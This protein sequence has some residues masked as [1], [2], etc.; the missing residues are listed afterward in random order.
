M[1]PNETSYTNCSKEQQTGA[2]IE[3]G[4]YAAVQQNLTALVYKI[5]IQGMML[6]STQMHLSS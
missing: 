6:I 1:L 4:H 2:T 5:C 3:G